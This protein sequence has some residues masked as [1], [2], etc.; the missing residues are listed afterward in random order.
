MTASI[1]KFSAIVP[2]IRA[3]CMA[4][5]AVAIQA[6]CHP[7]RRAPGISVFGPIA[8]AS[9]GWCL[10]RR[11]ASIQRRPV[12][13]P[14][15]NR[16]STGWGGG[17]AANRG[18]RSGARKP[19]DSDKRDEGQGREN[20][21]WGSDGNVE[22]EGNQGPGRTVSNFRGTQERR[23][24]Q[25]S[26]RGDFRDRGRDFGRGRPAGA[27]ETREELWERRREQQAVQAERQSWLQAQNER[28]PD[29]QY[30][31]G[32]SPVLAALRTKRRALHVLYIQETMELDKRKDKD[33]IAEVERLAEREGCEVVR[34]DKGRLNVMSDNRLHQVRSAAGRRRLPPTPP[35]PTAPHPLPH[36]PV[37]AAD[38]SFSPV[39]PP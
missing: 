5:P 29:S 13:P 24:G 25:D 35:H 38:P 1:H 2:Y 17:T 33:A 7:T 14:S 11:P 8:F 30:L 37:A 31:F 16:M 22:N 12:C 19:W 6:S 28:F 15:S 39:A 20:R 32:V 3:L 21:F 10:G 34:T 26:F 18:G 23:R 9:Q 27:E 36:P 4:A